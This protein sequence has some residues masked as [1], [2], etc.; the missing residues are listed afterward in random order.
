MLQLWYKKSLF[1]GILMED[2]GSTGEIKSL[3]RRGVQ[4]RAAMCGLCECQRSRAL[5]CR[6]TTKERALGIA[7]PG[8]KHSNT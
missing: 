3:Q 4:R 5:L 1:S 6:G 2:S 8:Q 7:V